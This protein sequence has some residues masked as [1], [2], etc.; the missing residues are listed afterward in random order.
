MDSRPQYALVILHHLW[1]LACVRGDAVDGLDSALHIGRP[2]RHSATL[3][4]GIQIP[5]T[6]CLVN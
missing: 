3:V 1:V 6:N 2:S 4:V 5:H